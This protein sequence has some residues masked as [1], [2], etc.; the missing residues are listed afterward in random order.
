[1]ALDWG[2]VRIGVAL[3]DPLHLT[4][5]ALTTLTHRD[6][7][8]DLRAI[9]ELVEG[10]GVQEII[11]GHPVHMSG[12]RGRAALAAE[13]FAERLQAGL[14]VPVRLWDERLTSREAERTLVEMNV[15][16]R[17]RAQAVDRLAAA[18]ILQSFLEFEGRQPATETDSSRGCAGE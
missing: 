4:A 13:R 18:V 11:V 9:R 1:M 5:R 2:E 17:R 15:K 8:R 10:H 14:D 6:A 3:S 12:E 16:R 7:G